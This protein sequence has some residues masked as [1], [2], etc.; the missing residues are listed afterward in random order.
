MYEIL[1]RNEYEK[2]D[3]MLSD[4]NV[5]IK[6]VIEFSSK[7]LS[8]S[9]E[10]KE[11]S[12]LLTNDDEVHKLNKEFRG[13]DKPTNVLSFETEDE[14]MLGDIVISIDT[15][16]RECEEQK[17]EFKNHFIHLIIHGFLHLLGYDHLDDKEADEMEKL[18]IDIMEKMGLESP[19]EI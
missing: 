9:L 10:G 5:I 14:E 3:E 2:M 18:E 17:K 13:K 7:E 1:I 6:D 12:F 19:Y 8:F 4:F 11:V 16:L 15:V